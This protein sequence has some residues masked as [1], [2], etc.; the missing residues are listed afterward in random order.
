M[1][2]KK[3]R[4]GSSLR[5]GGSLAAAAASLLSGGHAQAQEADL[6]ADADGA[7][8]YYREQGRVQ[9]IEPQLNVA[10]QVDEDDKFT[11]N[12][13]ADTLSGASPIGAV[14][15][16]LPQTFVRPYSI[17]PL[18]TPVTMTTA[19]GGSKV[20]LQ[21]PA[22][23]ATYQ[24]LGSSTDVPANT[25]PLD[26]GF[27]DQRY[28]GRLGW[29][30]SLGSTLK[31]DLGG[32][33]SHERDYRSESANASLTRDFDSHNTT[34][35]AGVNYERDKSFPVTGTPTPL[36]AMSADW[37]GTSAASHELDAVLGV[38][39]VLSRR[40]LASLSYSFGQAHGYL[41]DPYK[42]ISVVDPLSGQPVSQ[43]Y[44]A[45][46]DSRR[47]Q[48]LF[49]D[50][51]IH[52]PEDIVDLSLRAYKDDWGVKSLTADMRYH[53]VLGTNMYIEPHL[54]YYRQN[55]ADFFHYFLTSDSAAPQYASADTRLGKFHAL[56]YGVKFGMSLDD[57]TD[58][59]V[60]VEYYD[61][62]GNGSPAEAVGQLRQQNL[63]PALKAVTVL[64]GFHY[65][66][67][68]DD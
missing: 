58:W 63:F 62:V 33:Y 61:Q 20:V 13:T 43:L 24:I 35:N 51:R 57:N 22:S 16:S 14:P 38:T 28:A 6:T 46:P 30:R 19:S 25:L 3:A 36:T 23:G 45:R 17:V 42:L 2:L 60:R 64:L 29:E 34:L 1:Q 12:F 26:H 8:L 56:T 59:S 7:V 40:W 47:K 10:V 9:A 49:L 55:A 37:I 31:L 15:S 53:Y 41:T 11:L 18:G 65:S 52:L 32:A 5:I 54:R 4:A 66:F 21:P 67:P 48:S 50:N 44:E 68:D 39:Q 27:K